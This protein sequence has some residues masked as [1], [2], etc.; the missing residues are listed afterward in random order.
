MFIIIPLRS[1]AYASYLEKKKK[2]TE[3][4][5]FLMRRYPLPSI[6][7][8]QDPFTSF[9]SRV[10]SSCFLFLFL[11]T[12]YNITYMQVRWLGMWI[13]NFVISFSIE[14]VFN[15]HSRQKTVF[16]PPPA[17]YNVPVMSSTFGLFSLLNGISA[18]IKYFTK[19][20]IV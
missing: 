7:S 16:Y 15:I 5:F 19:C 14:I 4:S 11:P 18:E 1:T 6:Y 10:D 8:K 20:I 3:S 2:K 12:L 9:V 17:Q 13:L